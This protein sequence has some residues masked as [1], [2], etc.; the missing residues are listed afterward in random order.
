MRTG[1]LL[2]AAACFLPG[3]GSSTGN[4]TTAE[5]HI[6]TLGTYYSRYLAQ[7][8]GIP[9]AT[10]DDLKAF[11]KKEGAPAENF[12]ALFISP[13]DGDPYVV[14]LKKKL[15]PP[16]ADGPIV[17]HEKNG[18]DGERVV[19]L[20]TGEVRRMNEADFGKSIKSP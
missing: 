8:R 6:R 7:H 4:R 5:E 17:L 13:R 2:L 19:V 9:P 14:H 1:F 3:C 12:D 18:K 20:A 15:G 10:V 16:R 11:M